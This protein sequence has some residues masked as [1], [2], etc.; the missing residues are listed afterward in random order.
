MPYEYLGKDSVI[1]YIC[2]FNSEIEKDRSWPRLCDNSVSGSFR[3]I[4]LIQRTH[5]G[6]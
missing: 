3:P 6:T 1:D 2:Q 4:K 5:E